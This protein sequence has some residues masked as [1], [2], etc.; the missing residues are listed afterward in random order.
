MYK[1][2][3]EFHIKPYTNADVKRLKKKRT[4]IQKERVRKKGKEKETNER[5]RKIWEKE[6]KKGREHKKEGEKENV[7]ERERE[8]KYKKEK[9]SKK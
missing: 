1:D 9:R 3:T 7:W 6:E 5:S 4:N 2:F 8:K